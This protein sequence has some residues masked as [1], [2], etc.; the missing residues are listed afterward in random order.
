MGEPLVP[1]SGA[2]LYRLVGRE[3]TG[4]GLGGRQLSAF[5]GR[6][7]ELDLLLERVRQIHTGRG[8]VVGITGE[9]GIGKSRLVFELRERLRNLG[10]HC[11]EGRCVS[12]GTAVPYL[13]LVDLLRRAWQFDETDPPDDQAAVVRGQVAALGLDVDRVTPYLLRLFG[14]TE[15]TQPLAALSP[16]GLKRDTFEAL[17]EVILAAAQRARLVLLIEDLHWIDRSSEDFLLSLV[18]ALPGVPI[19]LVATARAGYRPPWMD[20]SYASQLALTPLS[21][22]DGLWLIHSI[23]SDSDVGQSVLRGLA[24]RG[25]G[26]PFFLEE[27]AW[28]VVRG[29]DTAHEAAWVP[30]TVEAALTARMDRLDEAPRQLL[31]LAAV[32]GRQVPMAVLAPLWPGD[33]LADHLR[34]LMQAEFLYEQ[35]PGAYIF[36]HVLT[37]EVAYA[38]LSPADRE[39]LNRAAGH[40]YEMLYTGRLD[41]I[42]DRLAHHFGRT[43]D[44]ARAVEYL[45]HAADRSAAAYA[46]VEA[47]AW[48][49]RALTH[50]EQLTGAEREGRVAS[51]LARH[52]Y[53]MLFVGQLAEGRDLLLKHWPRVEHLD[54]PTLS[55]PYCF[56]LAQILDHLGQVEDA[57]IWAE[58]AIR[59]ATRCRDVVTQ[60]KAHFE[61]SMNVFW[62]G[63]LSESVDHGQRAVTLLRPTTDRFFLGL[64]SWF[65]GFGLIWLARF[66]EALETA[67][68]T[69][70]VG[71]RAR[72][73][74]TQCYGDMI[75][76]WAH[77]C[78]GEVEHGVALLR[79]G[80]DLAQDPLAMLA[81][82][83]PLGFAYLEAGQPAAAIDALERSVTACRADGH[84]PLRRL[85]D[86]LAQ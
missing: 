86:G 38:R 81:V 23:L 74:R 78:L 49:N 47:L 73:P 46:L 62:R 8:H 35:A 52:A 31:A 25:E 34:S 77:T 16:E 7:H 37:Q 14:L 60:G 51:V 6:Q 39:R 15:G 12:H 59:E 29:A 32:L 41:E 30:D 85:D 18:D 57:A 5:V 82:A 36:K 70:D 66:P 42:C 65:T 2:P 28:T 21:E 67:R 1:S 45:I 84:P 61:L 26:N 13:P 33:R 83:G 75:A 10:V 4:F 17:R 19:L 44:H 69:R 64:A 79:R 80:L 63:R 11:L 50:A 22:Q 3:A 48:L 20:R 56:G 55:G 54:D 43:N 9:A 72:D 76:G 53:P 68:E 27:L 58:R 71:N 24:A 40:A